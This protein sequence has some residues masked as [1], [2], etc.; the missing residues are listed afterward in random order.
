M[1]NNFCF[2]V[3][4]QKSLFIVENCKVFIWIT[5]S[6]HGAGSQLKMWPKVRHVS[7]LILVNVSHMSRDSSE[8]L[9]SHESGDSS[10][11]GYSLGN[12]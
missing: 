5:S 12:A 1:L 7:L 11:P 9:E 3:N 10:E 6:I 2:H 4:A 8:S